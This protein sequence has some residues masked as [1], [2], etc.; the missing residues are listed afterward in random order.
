MQLQLNVV[1]LHCGRHLHAIIAKSLV[2]KVFDKTLHRKHFI[3]SL[4]NDLLQRV[5]RQIAINFVSYF[6]FHVD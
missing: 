1:V 2:C 3:V 6:I 4:V 5:D